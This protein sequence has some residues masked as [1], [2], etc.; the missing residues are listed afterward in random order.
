MRKTALS[1]GRDSDELHH[2]INLRVFL[3][4]AHFGEMQIQHLEDLFT[5]SVGGVKAR[6]RIL[7]NHRDLFTSKRKHFRLRHFQDIFTFIDDRPLRDPADPFR[8]QTQ[9]R[10]G[11]SGFACTC[12]PDKAAGF[13]FDKL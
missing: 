2:L 9:N 1:L 7:K 11:K 13:T 5:D 4:F 10:K 3:G 6:H 12:F 8:K